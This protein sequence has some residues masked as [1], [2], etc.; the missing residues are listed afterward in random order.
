MSGTRRNS[1]VYARL[2]PRLRELVED[3]L[4]LSL[5]EAAQA[6]GY[7]GTATLRQTYEG[8]TMPGVD[9]LA[10]LSEITTRDATFR[11]SLDWLFTGKGSP[12]IACASND[13]VAPNLSRIRRTLTSRADQISASIQ[14]L[15]EDLE[16]IDEM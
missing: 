5:T 15:K 8:K 2:G 7:V 9:K 11:P 14:S 4:G 13:T 10:R 16:R 1:D 6:L 3:R 12:L